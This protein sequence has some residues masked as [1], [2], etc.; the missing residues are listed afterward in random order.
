MI[1][2][3]GLIILLQVGCLRVATPHSGERNV[4][5]STPAYWDPDWSPAGTWEYQEGD[6]VYE[7][8]LDRNGNGNYEWQQG[9]LETTYLSGGQW[10]GKWIQFGNDR[11]GRFEA[12]LSSDGM[13]AQG[14]WWYTRI[15]E[16]GNPLEPGGEFVLKRKDFLPKSLSEAPS[17]KGQD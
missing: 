14:K 7:L 4:E 12:R 16:D 11:E 15:G 10:K 13:S 1:S 2:L 8:L 9:Q 6:V 3:C 5:K 17:P